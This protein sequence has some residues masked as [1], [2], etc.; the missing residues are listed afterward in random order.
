ME[1][2]HAPFS[3]RTDISKE[4]Y[5]GREIRDFPG[6]YTFSFSFVSHVILHIIDLR[7]TITTPS[8][9]N[10]GK[11]RP[12]SSSWST[13]RQPLSR[14]RTRQTEHTDGRRQHRSTECRTDS[15][16]YSSHEESRNCLHIQRHR[17]HERNHDPRQGHPRE[18]PANPQQRHRQNVNQAR[19]PTRCLT[20]GGL[21]TSKESA[22]N[23]DEESK[24][25]LNAQ[26]STSV[27][28]VP[29]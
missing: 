22:D 4:L 1:T 21:A 20:V 23:P 19:R 10:K 5:N 24:N 13:S 18:T 29:I 8:T 9:R 14:K 27:F 15:R 17:H 12:L 28:K 25:I 2:L 16:T 11:P 26:K 7:P 3:K 6:N